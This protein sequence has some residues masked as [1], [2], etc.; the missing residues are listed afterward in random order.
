M[1]YRKFVGSPGTPILYP[2]SQPM[3]SDNN[4]TLFWSEEIAADS[5]YLYRSTNYIVDVSSLTVLDSTTD[6]QYVDTLNETG[7]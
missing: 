2:I 4:I 6:L 5:Y 7:V 3:S 1:F